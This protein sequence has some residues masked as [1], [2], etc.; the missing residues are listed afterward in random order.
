MLAP[1]VSVRL[2]ELNKRESSGCFT[3]KSCLS[4]SS[5]ISGRITKYFQLYM[6]NLSQALTKYTKC[7]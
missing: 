3:V 6:T 7:T 4:V 1:T 2:L 5:N